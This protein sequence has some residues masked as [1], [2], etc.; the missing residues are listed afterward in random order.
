MC[1]GLIDSLFLLLLYFSIHHSASLST[2]LNISMHSVN[3]KHILKWSQLQTAC[4]TFNHTVQFQGEYELHK[5][6]GSWVDAYDCQEIRENR[7][8]LT[9]DLASNSDYSI[10]IKTNCDGQKSWTQLPKTFNRK[11]TVLLTP[12]MIVNV[13]GDPI[14]V[15]FNTTL[16]AITVK[17][18]VWTEG[19]EQNALTDMTR[20]YPYHFSIAAHRGKEKMCFRAEALVDAINKSCSTDTQCVIMHKQ[21][22]DMPVIVSVAVVIALAVAFILGW[23]VTRF[24]PQIKHIICHREPIPS[25]LFFTSLKSAEVCGELLD[26]L[27]TAEK[28]S[29]QRGRHSGMNHQLFQPLI[30]TADALPAATQ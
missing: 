6:N 10:R 2:Y 21:T 27:V 18:K 3:M 22:S 30:Y 23:S 1:S 12:E 26:T 28:L 24:S 20:A 11:D 7:C 8:D 9:H 15:G 17:L 16:S 4:S 29:L 13:E 25:A 5:L 14:Q 19:D